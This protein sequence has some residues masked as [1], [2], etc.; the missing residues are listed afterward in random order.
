M[1][2][3]S[4]NKHNVINVDE[5]REAEMKLKAGYWSPYSDDSDGEEYDAVGQESNYT[6]KMSMAIN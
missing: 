6:S 2:L 3:V 5:D 4:F 1:K